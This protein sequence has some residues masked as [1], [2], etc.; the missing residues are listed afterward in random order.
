MLLWCQ[1]HPLWPLLPE[2]NTSSTPQPSVQLI[3]RAS[4]CIPTIHF[5]WR[6]TF[7]LSLSLSYSVTRSLF[8]SAHCCSVSLS[9]C[10]HLVEW[11]R[12]EPHTSQQQRSV[13]PG[14]VDQ[15]TLNRTRM[16]QNRL[17]AWYTVWY[18]PRNPCAAEHCLFLLK[19]FD[20]K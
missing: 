13:Q 3:H 5:P 1:S 15:S 12:T 9:L 8:P 2:H 4:T 18:T 14:T 7:L 16:E 10:I 19:C 20:L 6:L 11:F 17:R